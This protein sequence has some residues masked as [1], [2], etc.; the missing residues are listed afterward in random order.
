MTQPIVAAI[1]MGY[2]HLRPAAAL[3]GYLET[4]VLQMDRPPLGNEH[5]HQFWER[6]RK[7]YEPLTRFSQL[8]GIGPPMRALLNTVTAIPDAWP[9]RDLSGPSQ[10]TR[11]MQRAA[12]EGV[13][14]V[15]A[16]HLLTAGAPLLST[17]YG[18]A[19]LAEMHGAHR[20]HCLVTDSDINRVWAPPE[21]G[22]SGIVY[23]APSDRARRRM[24]SYGVRADR[25]RLTGYPLPHELVGGRERMFLKQNLA[26]RLARLRVPDRLYKLAEPE[27]GPLP[28]ADGPPLIVFAVGG[29][30][31]QVPLAKQLIRGMRKQ[32]E[33]GTLRLALVAGRRPEVA[34]ALREA[35][36]Q[37]GL[38]PK[39]PEEP[40]LPATG[41]ARRRG[42]LEEIELLEDS[43]VFSYFRRLNALL[44]RADA[45]WSKPSE[46][47]F[48]AGLGLPFIS[49]PPVGVHEAW[50]LRWASD[51]GAALPQHDPALAGE[52][53]S[54]W[55][56]DGVLA[57]AALSGYWRL[58][59][60]GLYEICDQVLA[61]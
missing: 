2:G 45:L 56:E 49:A 15:L 28:E 61:S 39:D 24:L 26:C 1:D 34:D 48:F 38:T 16:K 6:T 7:L 32:L 13:G 25:V 55:L 33:Q 60:L 29:A 30:G 59:Q 50:N 8:P 12:G 27:L 21:P 17:F 18:A 4:Q 23:F 43:D 40:A 22:K 52:W 31:A 41:G 11:W 9:V 35:L 3:A 19:I 14:E 47:T 5:D 10:G 58:P 51:R 42:A 46:M 20:L 53:L 57:G 44:A 54:E 36:H 37:S